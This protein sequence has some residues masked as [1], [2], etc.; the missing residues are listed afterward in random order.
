MDRRTPTN[1]KIDMNETLLLSSI[2]TGGNEKLENKELEAS[3]ISTARSEITRNWKNA[4]DL[5]LHA[6][7]NKIWHTMLMEGMA[8]KIILYR[9]EIRHSQFTESLY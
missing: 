5:S 1:Q 7:T 4:Q 8:N 3:L 6:F 9:G 2:F